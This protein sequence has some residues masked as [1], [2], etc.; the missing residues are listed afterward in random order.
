MLNLTGSQVDFILKISKY[1]KWWLVILLN[2]HV[3]L[4]VTKFGHPSLAT[5]L[6]PS[7]LHFTLNTSP[8][9]PLTWTTTAS[10]QGSPISN[11]SCAVNSQKHDSCVTSLIKTH[12][13]LIAC[14]IKYKLLIFAFSLHELT[15]APPA[16]LILS[17]TTFLYTFYIPTN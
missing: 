7:P 8:S 2:S 15:P 14:Q 1:W 11:S 3:Q 13:F 9:L 5:S 6:I 16:C 4:L 10:L 17:P 12:I